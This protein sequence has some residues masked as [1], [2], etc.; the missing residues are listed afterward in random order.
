MEEA[1][2]K[3][4]EAAS[5]KSAKALWGK[6]KGGY[7]ISSYEYI[8]FYLLLSPCITFAECFSLSLSHPSLPEPL[9]L[10]TSCAV[11]VHFAGAMD[12]CL[13]NS[14]LPQTLRPTLASHPILRL[15]PVFGSRVRQTERKNG[16]MLPQQA[17]SQVSS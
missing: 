9:S 11:A 7:C 3:E 16:A 8:S 5:N 4:R 1:K 10:L 13:V 6:L 12:K 14:S 15:S 2:R 17:A